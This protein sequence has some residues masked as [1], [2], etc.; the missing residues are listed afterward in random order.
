MVYHRVHV[1]GAHE[2]AKSRSSE[3]LDAFLILPVRLGDDPDFIS[4]GFQHTADDRRSERRM[5]HIGVPAHIDEIA[6]IP[7]SFFHICPAYREKIMYHILCPSYIVSS[8]RQSDIFVPN[9]PWSAVGG[10]PKLSSPAVIMF[11][12]FLSASPANFQ[13]RKVTVFTEIF[14]AL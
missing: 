5:I 13:L 10:E 3:D 9:L 12:V 11:F 7:A 4:V 2:E 1:S 6:L 8:H 14:A